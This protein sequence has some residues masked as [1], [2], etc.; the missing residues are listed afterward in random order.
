SDS[1]PN[2]PAPGQPHAGPKPEFDPSASHQQRPRLRPIRGFPAQV[3][4]QT[5][6]GLADARQISDKMVVLPMAA[7]HLLPLMNGERSVGDIVN[8]IGKGLTAP[9]LQ[10]LIAQLDDAGLLFGPRFDAMLSAM[11]ADF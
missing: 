6:L 8:Q 9:I 11:H 3:G 5:M 4:G 10:G 1:T 2:V 7:Q